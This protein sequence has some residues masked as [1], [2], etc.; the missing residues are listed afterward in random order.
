MGSIVQGMVGLNMDG[1]NGAPPWV[2]GYG[3]GR[4]RGRGGYVPHR[5]RSPRYGGQRRSAPMRLE[6]RN[7]RPFS[8]PINIANSAFSL[9]EA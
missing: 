8:E 2:N 9:Q 4:R 1:D 5:Q 7:Q 6:P 3:R